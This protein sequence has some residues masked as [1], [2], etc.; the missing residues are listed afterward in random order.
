MKCPCCGN[1]MEKGGLVA[2][3]AA[4]VSWHPLKEFEKKWFNALYYK[5]GKAIGTFSFPT[6]EVKIPNAFYCGQCNKV[7]GVFDVIEP[8]R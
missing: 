7:V 5:E 8:E 6:K 2:S 1:E 3:G 4:A